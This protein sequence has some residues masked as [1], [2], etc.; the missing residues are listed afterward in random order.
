MAMTNINVI[1]DPQRGRFERVQA[2]MNELGIG[3]FI[4]YPKLLRLEKQLSNTQQNYQFNMYQDAADLRPPEVRL[5]R[6]DAFVCNAIGLAL[7]KPSAEGEEG[8][9]NLYTWP[10]TDVFAGVGEAAALQ[11][12]YNGLLT[13]KTGPVDRLKDFHTSVLE[14]NP[15]NRLIAATATATGGPVWGPGFEQRG[16]LPIEPGIIFDGSQDNRVFLSVGTG[17]FSTAVPAN[18]I[19]I[20]V[21]HMWGYLVEQGA[22]LMG[23]AYLAR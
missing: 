20:L 6:N 19:N 15:N 5:N 7:Y 9:A 16:M 12:L 21:F 4:V 23:K 22:N 1:A 18:G 3:K 13:I 17:D 2:T 10:N 11:Q 8:Q 14:Y